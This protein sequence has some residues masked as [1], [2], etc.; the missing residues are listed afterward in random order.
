[1]KKL[2]IVFTIAVLAAGLVCCQDSLDD[3]TF[4]AYD[5]QPVGIFLKQKAEYSEWVKLLERANLYNALNVNMDFTCFI[6]DNE[7]VAAYLKSKGYASV[8]DPAFT[9]KEVEY[10]MKYHIIP[11]VAYKQS[12]FS[13][14]LKDSTASGDYLTVKIREGGANAMYVNDTSLIVVKD[15]E[16]INGLM[17]ELENVLD[18]VT[19]TVWDVLNE[20]EEYSIMRDAI[21][22][23]GLK[24]WLSTRYLVEEGY[25][26]R[27][28]K[29]LFAVSNATFKKLKNINTLADLH[30]EYP[31]DAKDPE[32]NFYRFIAYHIINDNSDFGDL[33]TFDEDSKEKSK[34]VST[35]ADLTL[36]KI[37]ELSKLNTAEQK[38]VFNRSTDSAH[39]VVGKYD[40]QC[41]NGY[42]HEVDQ[43][44]EPPFE[45]E[46]TTVVFDFADLDA[47]RKLDI[48]RNDNTPTETKGVIDRKTTKDIEW[49]TVPDNDGAVQY[50]VK[51]GQSW[52][53]D[54]YMVYMS[55]GYVGW[56]QFRTP[57]IAKGTYSMK[58][59][60]I[61]YSPV[62]GKAQMYIDE[63]R[64]G[65]VLDFSANG[66]ETTDLGTIEFTSNGRHWVKF[67][68]IKK[69]ELDVDRIVFT[70][71]KN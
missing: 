71:V 6:A 10:L 47:F 53:L 41:M 32:S 27:D 58:L 48:Y 68:A 45:I 1:M 2:F 46:P 19:R 43:L 4:A 34:T 42:V 66:S 51:Q 35:K 18:P 60:K 63:K 50:Y 7:A 56:A 9:Q 37:E 64:V 20:Q 36:I 70:P 33:A 14:K 13:G 62:R 39:V 12:A 24:D 3:E 49:F 61:A 26:T 55:L 15:I 69:G 31:G 30:R 23:C 25:T 57:V 8:D 59:Y 54:R 29:T 11:G 44:L 52:S 67:S 5:E 22:E 16:T 40:I 65:P 28:Y 21:E 17:H 38:L